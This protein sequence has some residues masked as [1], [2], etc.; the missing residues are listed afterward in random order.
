MDHRSKQ[1]LVDKRRQKPSTASE[2]AQTQPKQPDRLGTEEAQA[3]TIWP[4]RVKCIEAAGLMPL[5]YAVYAGC[6]RNEKTHG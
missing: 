2:D 1:A 5:T 6:S 3:E 4:S